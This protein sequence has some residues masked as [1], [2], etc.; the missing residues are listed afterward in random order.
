MNE[1]ITSIL[2]GGFAGAGVVAV[3]GKLLIDSRLKKSSAKYQHELDLKK[4][5]LQ[6]DLSYYGHQQNQKFSRY[7]ES[8]RLALEKIYGSIVSTSQPRAGFKKYR[9]SSFPQKKEKFCFMYFEAFSATFKSF[10][11][12]FQKIS[13]SFATIEAQ[14]IYIDKET[15]RK[16]NE[17][18]NKIFNY[19]STRFSL[20]HDAHAKA[21]ELFSNNDLSQPTAP[22]DFE[23]FYN[24]NQQQWKQLT[25]ALREQ[26]KDHLRE[27]LKPK[28]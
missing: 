25:H 4:D 22:L 11:A 27:L 20:F 26:L 13:A 15:E 14:A 21:Q 3:L 2:S 7:D 10:D 28:I 1:L 24:G 12:V 6:S 19:Y 17:T 18:M 9:K 8:K 23:G 16:V 5:Q